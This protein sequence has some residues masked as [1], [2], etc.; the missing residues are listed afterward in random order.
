MRTRGYFIVFEGLDGAG[1]TTQRDRL[2]NY[3]AKD[4]YSV[5]S[6]REPGGT[7]LAESIRQAIQKTEAPSP[8]SERTTAL[9]MNACRSDHV[10][11]VIEPSLNDKKIV[12]CDR[13]TLS[14]LAYQGVEGR[15][16]H[17]ELD[18]VNK[19]AIDGIYPDLTI[20]LNIEP[21][22]AMER[23]ETRDPHIELFDSEEER[24]S[25]LYHEYQI[26]LDKSPCDIYTIDAELPA[27]TIAK[28]IAAVVDN[29]IAKSWT[30]ISHSE[31]CLT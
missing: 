5:V 4:G 1:K 15:V 18:K 9:L 10:E 14:T 8:Y 29:R 13:Y 12:I 20:F 26:C 3:L 25:R 23:L 17:E 30:C 31:E 11:Q 28:R 7:A 22:V 24:L 2:T 16:D 19:F 27:K 21:D 6:T